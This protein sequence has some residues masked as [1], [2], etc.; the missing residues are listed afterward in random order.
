MKDL[1]VWVTNRPISH[2]SV[3]WHESFLR[4]WPCD[5]ATSENE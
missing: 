1:D 2:V 3:T 5:S 4:T